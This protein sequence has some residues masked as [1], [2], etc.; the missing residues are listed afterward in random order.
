MKIG[1][2]TA[3]S[4]A[5][6]LAA[7]T[8]T[9]SLPYWQNLQ[10][11]NTLATAV[12]KN[13]H[14]PKTA[15]NENFPSGT[16][17]VTFYYDNGRLRAPHIVQ[18]TGSSLLDAAII[19]QIADI[20]PPTADGL[21]TTTP[22]G[23]QMNIDMYPADI[24]M[25]RA[26]QRTLQEHIQYPFGGGSGGTVVAEFKYRDGEILDP[27]IKTSSGNST[28]DHAVMKELQ[29]T[30]LPK[31]PD[32]LVNKTFSFELPYCF[33][34][35]AN[36]C[37][38]TVTEVRYVPAGEFSNSSKAPCAEVGY[39]YHEGVISNVRLIKSS[40]ND[41]LDKRTLAEA[42]QGKLARPSARFDRA[43]TEYTVP[44]CNTNNPG[45]GSANQ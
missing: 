20:K 6:L 41:G 40:G 18:S 26:I 15:A 32:W 37:A 22:H 35:G 30:V 5:A 24:E 27:K 8:T 21:D 14:Y 17:V 31:P 11:V 10:W 34:L 23:F 42:A 3:W 16:A 43:V 29:T 1:I 7:C 19:E 2:F 44:V 13:I 25:F 4:L 33:G 12:H 9:Q 38:A 28:L 36:S 39:R 45:A